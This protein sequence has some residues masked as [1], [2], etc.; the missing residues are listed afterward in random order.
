MAFSV[1]Q[2][3]FFWV[4]VLDTMFFAINRPFSILKMDS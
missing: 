1:E 2:I 3:V 4:C